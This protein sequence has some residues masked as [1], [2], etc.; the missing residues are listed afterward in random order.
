MIFVF[1]RFVEGVWDGEGV[2]CVSLRAC[3]ASGRA[4]ALGGVAATHKKQADCWFWLH[5]EVRDPELVGGEKGLGGR[6]GLLVCVESVLGEWRRRRLGVLRPGWHVVPKVPGALSGCAAQGA[7]SGNI[8]VVRPTWGYA[9]QPAFR[10]TR[11]RWRKK[12]FSVRHAIVSAR[13][14]TRRALAG[15]AQGIERW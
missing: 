8:D 4:G 3:A 15:I 1:G 13:K 7:R 5:L 14:R 12:T 9:R 10:P 11:K 6:R 2:V